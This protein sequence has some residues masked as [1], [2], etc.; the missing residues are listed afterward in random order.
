MAFASALMGT[1]CS[2]G[3]CEEAL[4]EARAGVMAAD[5][6][7][8]EVQVYSVRS[9]CGVEPFVSPERERL[10]TRGRAVPSPVG[11]TTLMGTGVL[12]RLPMG[13]S[14]LLLPKTA[15]TGSIAGSA[16]VNS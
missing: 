12:V 7:A 6:G 5:V 1:S 13:V 8:V 4:F 16:F 11:E 3:I 9:V 10:E 15:W 14:Y 2:K